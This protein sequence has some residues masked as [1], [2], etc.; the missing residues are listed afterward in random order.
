VVSHQPAVAGMDGERHR[1]QPQ[2]L[3]QPPRR[4]VFFSTTPT[5]IS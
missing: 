3:Q 5:T 2:N 4:G 1:L